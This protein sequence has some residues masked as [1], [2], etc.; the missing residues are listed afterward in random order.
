M[1]PCG[2]MVDT[3]E[4]TRRLLGKE[5]NKG[6]IIKHLEKDKGPENVGL[7]LNSIRPLV[8]LSMPIIV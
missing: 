7:M 2:Q 5:V 3:N 1:A 8:C 4:D 6:D